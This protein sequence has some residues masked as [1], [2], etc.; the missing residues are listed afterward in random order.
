MWLLHANMDVHL[1]ELI[2]E[3]GTTCDTAAHRGWK[4]LSN[5]NLVAAAVRAGFTC[6]LTRDRLFAQ[7]ASRAIRSHPEFAVVLV[8]LPQ[9]PWDQ[10]KI[11]FISA[12]SSSPI[13]PQPGQNM[14]WP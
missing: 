1:A 11:F 3:L 9:R 2:S 12:W 13:N 4:A 14:E 6:I 10:Y 7:S 8:N 5:G